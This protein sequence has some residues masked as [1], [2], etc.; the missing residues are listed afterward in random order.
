[1]GVGATGQS[2]QWCCPPPESL[3]LGASVPLSL[4]P[5]LSARQASLLPLFPKLR[6]HLT[7]APLLCSLRV[8]AGGQ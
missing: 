6:G 5:V 8:Q 4:L 7:Y 1:M 3:T 2:T